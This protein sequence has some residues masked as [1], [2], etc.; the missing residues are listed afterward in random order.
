ALARGCG[1]FRLGADGVQVLE[2]ANV[3]PSVGDGQRCRDIVRE[4]VGGQQLELWSRLND[5]DS[6]RARDQIHLAVCIDRGRAVAVTR[7]TVL[8]QFLAALG[9]QAGEITAFAA[10]I[11]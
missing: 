8:V 9:I 4:F 6:T 1:L 5:A 10:Q 11:N 2:A 3:N 7:Q